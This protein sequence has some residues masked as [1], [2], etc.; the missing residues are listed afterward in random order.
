[1]RH[2]IVG[3]D[4][5]GPFTGAAAGALVML[6]QDANGQPALV[7][8]SVL[9]GI[10][11]ADTPVRFGV[12]K[13]AA[14]V[15][16]ALLNETAWLKPSEITASGNFYPRAYVAAVDQ[17]FK[18]NFTATGA[19]ATDK[20]TI[21]IVIEDNYS[22]FN[23]YSFEF[24][25]GASADTAATNAAAAINARLAKGS[26]PEVVS[27]AVDGSDTS[28]INVTLAAG[29][30]ASF[31]FDAQGSTIAIADATSVAFVFGHGTYDEV[32]KKEKEQL[33]RDVSNYDRYTALPADEV[34]NVVAGGTYHSYSFTA[35]NDAE[36]QIRGVDN[37][38]S[39]QL[40]FPKAGTTY[41]DGENGDEHSGTQEELA[42]FFIGIGAAD[43]AELG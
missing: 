27:A 13:E 4:V 43:W 14:S 19:E 29:V 30:R 20:A 33:G 6:Y 36:G 25:G 9:A 18:K 12:L 42:S 35:K 15:S 1:M 5:A 3:K 26:M 21:K 39:Y 24:A 16:L 11:A 7:Q 23:S 31:I 32:V 41:L 22:K 10:K 38:R 40:Y 28:Q 17:V 2:V 34:L 37:M 8:N